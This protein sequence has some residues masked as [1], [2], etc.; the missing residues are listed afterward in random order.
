MTFQGSLEPVLLLWTAFAL[1]DD[2]RWSQLD[3]PDGRLC[4]ICILCIFAGYEREEAQEMFGVID[5]DHGGT[6]SLEE[7]I[8][9]MMHNETGKSQSRKE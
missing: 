2:D 9:W 8:E 5:A 7:F 1:C 3:T 6:V 4:A